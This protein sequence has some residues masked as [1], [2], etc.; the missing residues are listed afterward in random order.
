MA[1]F[2]LILLCLGLGIAARRAPGYHPSA[3]GTLN[4]FVLHVSLPAVALLSLHELPLRRELVYPAAMAWVLFALGAA[5]FGLLGRAGGPRY[6][7]NRGTTGAL[8]LTGALANTSFVGFPLLVALYGPESLRIGVV[9]DQPGSFLV[10][11]SLGVLTATLC[12]SGVAS[13]LP[14]ARKPSAR[15][16]LAGISGRLLRFPPFL[17]MLA[18]F[19]LH[20]WPYPAP[21]RELLEKLAV[22][23]IPLALVSVGM[24]MRLTPAALRSRA[25]ELAIGLGFKLALAPAAIF[26][27]YVLV[28]GARGE[29]IQITLA[30][31]AMA[32]MITGA[33]LASEY[34][35]DPELANLMI[36]AGIPLSLLTV[37]LWAH[38]TRWV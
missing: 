10:L 37:P 18:A 30:E 6:G 23:L 12:A 38:F 11:S 21:F 7:W 24:Q 34:G 25:R 5:F 9:A 32:P 13:G 14:G 16:L 29:A 27:L 17:A 22:T 8:I 31:A 26:A 33:I 3:P 15:A 4:R 20:P 1:N 36:G 2:G 28:L 35:L 19:A